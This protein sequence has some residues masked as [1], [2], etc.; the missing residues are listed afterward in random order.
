MKIAPL[1]FLFLALVFNPC[2]S[3]TVQRRRLLPFRPRNILQVDQLAGDIIHD[4]R[5][6]LTDIKSDDNLHRKQQKVLEDVIITA[7]RAADIGI[8]IQKCYFFLQK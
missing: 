7:L 2:K 1:F 6:I 4:L 3:R 5:G 8:Y